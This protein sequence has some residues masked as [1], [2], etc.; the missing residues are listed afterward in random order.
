MAFTHVH[1]LAPAS[2][3][4]PVPGSFGHN[5]RSHPELLHL[6]NRETIPPQRTFKQGIPSLP[7]TLHFSTY[8][9]SAEAENVYSS[10]TSSSGGSFSYDQRSINKSVMC[11]ERTSVTR[12]LSSAK[13]NDFLRS[14]VLVFS[15]S[16]SPLSSSLS[17]SSSSNDEYPSYRRYT[18][19]M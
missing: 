16:P 10:P 5:V 9:S 8:G 19:N 12:S 15:K 3:P 1:A 4:A 7:H 11:N 17:S 13:E 2:M 14:P 6:V 18:T